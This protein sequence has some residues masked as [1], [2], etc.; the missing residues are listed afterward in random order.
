MSSLQE[1]HSAQVRT[2]GRTFHHW[3]SNLQ[4]LIK[5]RTQA[6]HI[7]GHLRVEVDKDMYRGKKSDWVRKETDVIKIVVRVGAANRASDGP[8]SPGKAVMIYFHTNR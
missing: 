2:R 4:H 3:Y 8:Y 5:K 6:G 1:L 7:D